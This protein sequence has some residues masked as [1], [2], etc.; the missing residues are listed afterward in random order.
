MGAIRPFYIMHLI[1]VFAILLEVFAF[2]DMR[3]SSY[4][5]YNLFVKASN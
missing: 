2:I 5:V 3:T 4:Q 1:V